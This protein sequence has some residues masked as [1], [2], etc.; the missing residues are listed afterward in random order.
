MNLL[1]TRL[2][3]VGILLASG[4][5]IC[6][7][8]ELLTFRYDVHPTF[9]Q[10]YERAEPDQRVARDLPNSV[11]AQ[12]TLEQS[13]VTF[14]EGASAD[15]DPGSSTITVTNTS[16]EIELVEALLESW[17]RPF[18]KNYEANRKAIPEVQ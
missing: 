4:S 5:N 16:V 15:F 7:A 18:D 8:D 14:G 3:I 11:R 1:R 2:T 17:H 12:R 6:R 13:G 10:I 9:I